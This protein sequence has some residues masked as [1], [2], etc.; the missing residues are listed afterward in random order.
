M[1]KLA[2][3]ILLLM[4]AALSV[5]MLI[6]DSPASQAIDLVLEV[7][8]DAMYIA[9]QP[10]TSV[11]NASFVSPSRNAFVIAFAYVD[12]QRGNRL[13]ESDL[14][15]AGPHYDVLVP[16]SRRVDD[17]EIVSAV[18]YEDNGNGTF[19]END[20]PLLDA[21]GSGVYATFFISEAAA[22]ANVTAFDDDT[23]AEVEEIA[24]PGEVEEV[25]IEEPV[26]QDPATDPAQ[27]PAADLAAPVE[28]PVVEPTPEPAP[29]PSP[30]PSEPT[31]EPTPEP[32]PEPS[33]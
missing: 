30:E 9:D 25:P 21:G 27:D 13:G 23:G 32:T 16:L 15:T 19:D 4:G 17:G 5:Y 22:S 2:F 18:L 7:G 14:I 26:V 11:L 1:K 6:E 8:T 3:P 24:E 10:P 29:E 20:V 33:F 28:E 31:S 12:G